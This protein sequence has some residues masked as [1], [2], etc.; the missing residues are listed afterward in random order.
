MNV[1][2]FCFHEGDID[3]ASEISNGALPI[4]NGDEKIVRQL[5]NDNCEVGVFANHPSYF[6]KSVN[7]DYKNSVDGVNSLLEFVQ[8]LR[9]K[10]SD[11]ELHFYC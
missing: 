6:I 5:I 10:S 8:S 9:D 4:V 3:F 11:S 7:T 2:A 1:T